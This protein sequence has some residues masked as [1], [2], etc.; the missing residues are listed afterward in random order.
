[1]VPDAGVDHLRQ[2]YLPVDDCVPVGGRAASGW[3]GSVVQCSVGSVVSHAGERCLERRAHNK[4]V[5][6]LFT[7]GAVQKSIDKV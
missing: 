3:R 4:P 6:F 5:P 1:M 2:Q 7:F